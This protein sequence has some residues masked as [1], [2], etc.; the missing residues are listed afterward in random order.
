MNETEGPQKEILKSEFN[1]FLKVQLKKSEE[2]SPE[3]I[4]L[5][6]VGDLL[7]STL[8]PMDKAIGSLEQRA[9]KLGLEK[10]KQAMMVLGNF[11]SRTTAY[12]DRVV[13][14][15]DIYEFRSHLL[16]LKEVLQLVDGL[17]NSE[18]K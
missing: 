15:G 14:G 16:Q 17:V 8:Y 1:E 12:A 9:Y 3:E 6:Q 11:I 4:S 18:L 2:I 7:Q 10:M 13:G 5:E